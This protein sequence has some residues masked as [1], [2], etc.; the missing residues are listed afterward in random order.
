MRWILP[1]IGATLAH[2]GQWMM[3]LSLGVVAFSNIPGLYSK[4]GWPGI[5]LGLAISPL[6]LAYSPIISVIAWNVPG[7]L[8]SIVAPAVSYGVTMLGAILLVKAEEQE[9]MRSEMEGG[10]DES[11]AP[12]V[13]SARP[14][15]AMKPIAVIAAIILFSAFAWFVWPTRYDYGTPKFGP[16]ITRRD[17]L[18]NEMQEFSY[19]SWTKM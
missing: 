13:P 7:M 10:G 8:A 14:G 6:M 19:G 16:Y 5:L 18:T 11:E 1:V 15:D 9:E 12:R 3:V 2:L 17:R 4:M